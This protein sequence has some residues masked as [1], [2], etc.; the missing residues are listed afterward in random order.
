MANSRLLDFYNE[1]WKQQGPD[2]EIRRLDKDRTVVRLSPS[3]D[4]EI[5]LPQRIGIHF[6]VGAAGKRIAHCPRVSFGA[7]CPICEADGA[8]G[9]KIAVRRY[10]LVNCILREA[11]TVGVQILQLPS[12]VCKQV[13]E[14]LIDLEDPVELYDPERGHDLIILRQGS[15]L[16]TRY[17]VRPKPEPST[18]ADGPTAREWIEGQRDLKTFAKSL[19][20][21]QEELR[22]LLPI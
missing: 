7:P 22:E 20:Q 3:A 19:L 21:S 2:Q 5:Q 18:L 13:I 12:T 14:Y 11:E 8:G 6:N 9:K 17:Q 16:N 10:F 1:N 4:S 15:G